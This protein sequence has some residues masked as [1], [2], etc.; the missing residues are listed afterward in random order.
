LG[1]RRKKGDKKISDIK[2]RAGR[3]DL[4]RLPQGLFRETD[5]EEKGTA[6]KFHLVREFL[7]KIL[8]CEGKLNWEGTCLLIIQPHL[9]GI[10]F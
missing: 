9:R 10:F 4:S 1:G 3:G 5:R 2:A 7:G 8:V 6:A